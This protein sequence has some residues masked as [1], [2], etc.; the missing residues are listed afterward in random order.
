MSLDVA[1]D[2]IGD[3]W[4]GEHGG[5]KKAVLAV[6]MEAAFCEQALERVGLTPAI[7]AKT[8]RRLPAGM[9]L[10]DEPAAIEDAEAQPSPA[11]ACSPSVSQDI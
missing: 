5:D 8:A 9:G 4:A 6:S 7:A 11:F 2:L 3:R 10:S 1:R